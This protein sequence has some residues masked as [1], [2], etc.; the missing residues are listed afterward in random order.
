[1]GERDA[2]EVSDMRNYV[3]SIANRVLE[4]WEDVM[5][6]LNATEEEYRKEGWET[7]SVM[8]GGVTPLTT[9]DISDTYGLDIV[10]PDNEF[11]ELEE[12]IE[13]R[14]LNFDEFEVYKARKSG[15]MF[16]VVVMMATDN[17]FALLYPAYY[18]PSRSRGMM[19]EAIEKGEMKTHIRRLKNDKAITFNHDD[20]S[21][22]LPE[23]ET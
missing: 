16:L 19:K 12:V 10:L 4:N 13:E 9:S 23:D 7:L 11:L 20:P 8:P 1:M 15:I 21:L 3:E 17:K 5:E 2:D 18:D 14:D 6:D 22:F